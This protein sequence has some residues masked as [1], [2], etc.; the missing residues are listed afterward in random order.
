MINAQS[1]AVLGA[2]G[3]KGKQ[4]HRVIEY[5]IKFGYKGKIY[6][7]NPRESEIEGLKCYGAVKDIPD[8]V[9]LGILCLPNA[10]VPAAAQE[11]AEKGIKFLVIWAAGFGESEAGYELE[12]QLREICDTH[13]IKVCGPN[14]LGMINSGIGL[15]ATFSTALSGKPALIPGRVA[16]IS[17]SGGT[18]SAIIDDLLNQGFGFSVFVSTGNE[19]NLTF[20][21][22]CLELLDYDNIDIIA[23]YVEGIRD[24]EKFLAA[25]RKA[26]ELNKHIILV[27]GGRSRAAADA[28]RS[29]T[30]AIAGHDGA[31]RAAFREVGIIQAEDTEELEDLIKYLSSPKHNPGNFGR[32][33]FVL[34]TG[35]GSG[36]QAVDAVEKRLAVANISPETTEEIKKLVPAFAGVSKSVLDVTPQMLADPNYIKNLDALFEVIEKDPS[37][38]Q[39][40]MLM[41]SNRPFARQ[42]C[43]ALIR[44]REKAKKPL[45]VI[46]RAI[47]D[48]AQEMMREAQYH[49]F[50]STKRAIQV[51]ASLAQFNETD[52]ARRIKSLPVR[53]KPGIAWP[54]VEDELRNGPAVLTEDVVSSWLD[55][56]GIN[57]AAGKLA[58]NGDEAVQA[59]RA[60]GFPV[61]VKVISKG[62]PHRSKFNLIALDIQ[63]EETL[64][65]KCAALIAAAKEKGV[66]RIDGLW[67]QQFRP[68]GM[69]LIVGG[70]RNEPFGPVLMCGIGGYLAEFFE[71]VYR[72]LPIDEA[73]A[74]KMLSELIFIKKY[75]GDI[76]REALKQTLLKF[77]NLLMDCPWE[78]FEV[79][80]NPVKVLPKGRGTL[81]VDALAI[82]RK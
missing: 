46:W 34:T 64:R 24:G 17:Q 78:N 47:P 4:G 40:M 14:S 31:Y 39:I 77:S 81:A 68:E 20:A 6:P 76:D 21:D 41:A 63:D 13:G 50:D 16:F 75:P 60:L 5:L 22:Y 30:G 65:E 58:A 3:N 45:L 1:V 19:L 25:G 49:V 9:D 32:R 57:I 73:E 55:K 62:L 51:I 66:Q 27:K 53:E 61:V 26:R 33:T 43:E 7:V 71:P 8:D 15:T 80:I 10:K 74:E 12:R 67:V 37:V 70:F 52:S 35:G 2:S 23:G 54:A 72:L 18:A 29:H 48:I 59:A 79:E 56:Y 36:V 69:E 11:C 82:V 42:I 38:D 28:V 44:H